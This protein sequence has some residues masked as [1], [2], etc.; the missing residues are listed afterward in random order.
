LLREPTAQVRSHYNWFFEMY[1][2]GP[3]FYGAVP[4]WAKAVSERIRSSDVSV[5]SILA[6]LVA[7]PILMNYQT[8]HVANVDRYEFV[9]TERRIDDLLSRM[10]GHEI[11]IQRRENVSPY[12]FDKSAFEDRR[13][14][15]FL[16]E[17]NRLDEE[18]Y[19]SVS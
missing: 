13:V 11:A 7:T 14:R 15:D 3:E 17:H 16:A 2:R 1:D 6:N 9:A 18:L 10:L 12:R 5:D 8:K 19:R 4:K